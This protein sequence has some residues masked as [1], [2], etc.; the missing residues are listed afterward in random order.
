MNEQDIQNFWNAHP[1][2][3]Q[4]VGELTNDYETFFRRYDE[5]RYKTE[6]H[7]LTSLDGIDFH[8]KKVLEIG[9]GQGADSEQII[10]RG[11]V[12]SGIDLTAEAV[13]RVTTRLRLRNLPY[14][15]IERGTV[16]NMPFETDYFDIV[17]SHGVLHHVPDILTA[18]AEIARVTKPGGS[19]II[20]VYAKRSLNYILSIA[21]FRR[22]GLL[23]LYML[24]A[25]RDGIVGEHLENARSTGIFRYLKMENFS[26]KNTDGPKNPYS[27][28]Y[29]LADVATDFP[30]FSV[31]RS[32]Q[33]FMHAP[34]IPVGW[35]PLS[36]VL[37]WHL[38]VYLTP[39]K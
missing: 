37:G 25:R 10:R 31:L 28:I 39:K 38:W 36:R 2:G 7:I 26:H 1:C 20:M 3:E 18:Q 35:L 13:N 5:F 8:N 30:L 15:R 9:L 29:S 22:M 21:T 14:E 16:L 24:K 34:P 6:G 4:L 19:L 17:F 32:H 27:K 12:W 33:Q 23:L 11:A